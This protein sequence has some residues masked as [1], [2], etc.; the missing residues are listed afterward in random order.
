MGASGRDLNPQVRQF[1]NSLDRRLGVNDWISLSKHLA[2]P[3]SSTWLSKSFHQVCMM[4]FHSAQE[5]A[6]EIS[7]SVRWL[8]LTQL[9]L[10]QEPTVLLVSMMADK[11]PDYEDDTIIQSFIWR[12]DSSIR[13][14]HLF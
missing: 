11:G 5:R 3:A 14:K 12:E 1:N 9:S 6:L 8:P 13:D 7:S 4:T 10:C 2:P